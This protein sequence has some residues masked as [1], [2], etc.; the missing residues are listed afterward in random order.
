MAAWMYSFIETIWNFKDSFVRSG[1]HDKIEKFDN[2]CWPYLLLYIAHHK[3]NRP[4]V[5]EDVLKTPL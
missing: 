5:A 1:G 4:G 2:L 3:V